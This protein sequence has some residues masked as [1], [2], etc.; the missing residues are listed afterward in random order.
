MPDP[1]ILILFV[2]GAL[3]ALVAWLPLVFRRAPLSLP[4]ICV[5]LG[6]G[7]FSL[8]QAGFDPLPQTFPDITERL[9]EFVVI[10]ALMGAGLKIDRIFNLKRWGVTWRLLGVTMMLSIAAIVVLGWTVLGL[11]LA[12]AVLLA[13][14]L[15]PTDPVLASDVQVGAPREGGEDEVRFGLTSE[16]G[17]NDGLA[18]PFVNLAIALALAASGQKTDWFMD[19]LTVNVLWEIGAGL[20]IGWA[21]GWLFGWLTFTIP[22]STRLAATRDGFIVLAATFIS[23]SVTEML[24]CYGFLAVFIT[25]LAFRHADR[26]HDFHVEMHDFIEQIERMAM[27]VVLVLFGG[28]LVSGLLSPLRPLDVAVAVVIVL[29]VR[30]VAGMIGFIGYRRPLREKLILAF[31]GIR[32]VGSFYY[33]AYGLNAAPFEGGD[34]LWAIVG[35]ICLMSI[36]LHG[37]TVTPVMRWFDRSQGRDPDAD[38][39]EAETAGRGMSV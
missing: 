26:D 9:T 27:M 12:G 23:Y 25:A 5:I 19:W 37:I 2:V 1:Y 22:V 32:G 34:R 6:A 20:A 36:L 7:L 11:G 10:V 16:A 21:V 31:F 13:G 15:A 14:T 35:L 30:P 33:L 24:H 39:D 18:F 8:P 4:I 17:L 28:A 38:A 29:V 3:V